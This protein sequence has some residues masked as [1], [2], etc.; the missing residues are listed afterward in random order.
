MDFTKEDE[1]A[2]KFMRQAHNLRIAS[3]GFYT[4][5]AFF[6]GF[7]VGYIITGTIFN[8]VDMNI[9]LFSAGIGGGLLI[10]GGICTLLA[11]AKI[12]KGVKVF[13]NSVRQNDNASLDLGFSPGGVMLRLNF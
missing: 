9:L 1:M 2:Y 3:I 11:N 10:G 8:T 4:P 6:I 12:L 5:A 7:S 13:N